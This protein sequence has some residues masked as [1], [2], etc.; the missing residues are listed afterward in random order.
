MST[1][2][3]PVKHSE[4]PAWKR[5]SGG[6][7]RDL[8]TAILWRYPELHEGGIVNSRTH[9]A[10]LIKFEGFPSPIRLGANSI[11]WEPEAVRSWIKSRPRG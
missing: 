11:A 7:S 8:N 1:T 9:L 5:S 6:H 4:L 2:T 3:T 10:R